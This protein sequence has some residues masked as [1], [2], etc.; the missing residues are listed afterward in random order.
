MSKRMRISESTLV[1]LAVDKRF[2]WM[3]TL[4]PIRT[5]LAMGKRMLI[6]GKSCCGRKVKTDIPAQTFRSVISFASFRPELLRLKEMLGLERLEVN[7]LGN[8][9]RV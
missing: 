6:R 5:Q 4:N 8:S 9:F 2:E 7:I 1:Q 3:R